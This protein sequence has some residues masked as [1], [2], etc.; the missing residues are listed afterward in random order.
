MS[1]DEDKRKYR[2]GK[3]VS[4]GLVLV[5]IGSLFLMDKMHWVDA[6]DYWYLFPALIALSGIILIFSSSHPDLI[7]KG[8]FRIIFAFWLYASIEHLWGWTFHSSWPVI[9]IAWGIQSIIA[10]IL[11]NRQ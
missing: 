2:N 4:F 9:L 10:G 6:V 7:A 1:I 5:V 11:S 8:V 3:N